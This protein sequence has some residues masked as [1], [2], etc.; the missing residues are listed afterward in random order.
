MRHVDGGNCEF[1]R[2][3]ASRPRAEVPGDDAFG[4]RDDTPASEG[5]TPKSLGQTPKFASILKLGNLA[6]LAERLRLYTTADGSSGSA[7]RFS[8]AS[9]RIDRVHACATNLN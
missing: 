2:D 4:P 7:A 8:S 9:T 6:T 3:E 5:Q 1:P